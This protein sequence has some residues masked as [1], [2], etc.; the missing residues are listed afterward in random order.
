M[1][2]RASS[3]YKVHQTQYLQTL[4]GNLAV[5]GTYKLNIYKH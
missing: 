2:D 5:P 4:N 3:E 1:A